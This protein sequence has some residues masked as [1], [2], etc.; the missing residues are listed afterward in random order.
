MDSTSERST[1][2]ASMRG[3]GLV[4]EREFVRVVFQ[5]GFPQEVGINGCRVDDVIDVAI[6]RLEDYQS[7]SLACEENEQAIRAL[8]QAK[9][10]LQQRTHRRQDQGVFN[11]MRQ[12]RTVR[13]ED[14]IDDF[15]ATGS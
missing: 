9:H 1:K 5:S 11:T 8:L 7:G 6:E 10:S 4:V 15:S 2:M 13:T 14:V 12:H 3:G